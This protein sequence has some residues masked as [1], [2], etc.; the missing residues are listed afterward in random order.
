MGIYCLLHIEFVSQD[1]KKSYG[2]GWW[3]PMHNIFKVLNTTELY[4]K[5]V[6]IINLCYFLQLF[7]KDIKKENGKKEVGEVRTDEFL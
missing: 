3:W 1:E 2:D 6:K 7:K 4:L 5:M